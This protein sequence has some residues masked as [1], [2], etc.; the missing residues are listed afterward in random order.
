MPA[1]QTLVSH[2]AGRISKGVAQPSAERTA[3][4][5]AGISCMEAVFSTMSRHISLLAQPFGEFSAM[6]FAA[7]IPIGVAAFPKPRRFAQMLALR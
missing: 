3:A 5:L 6:R 4:T 2:T 1:E 7:C